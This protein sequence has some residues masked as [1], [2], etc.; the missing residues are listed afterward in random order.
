MNEKAKASCE[1]ILRLSRKKKV[2]ILKESR[3]QRDD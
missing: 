1:P 2:V 3:L